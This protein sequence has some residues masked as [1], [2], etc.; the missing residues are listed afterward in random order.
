MHRLSKRLRLLTQ[1]LIA[2]V[3]MILIA[4]WLALIATPRKDPAATD[5]DGQPPES[6]R[7]D[8]RSDD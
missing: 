7:V 8:V 2:S 1:W 6:Q 3:V 5:A 4:S